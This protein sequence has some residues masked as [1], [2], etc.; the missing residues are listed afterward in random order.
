MHERIVELCSAGNVV[1]AECVSELLQEAGIQARIVGDCL[2]GAAGGLPCGEPIAPRI[3]VCQSDLG[4]A[5]E[6]IDQWCSQQTNE[7]VEFPESETLPESETPVEAEYA[8]LPSDVR[9][10][11]LSQGFFIVGAV[12]IVIGGIWAWKNSM[13]LSIYSGTAVGQFHRI[14]VGDVKWVAPPRER[15]VPPG[16]VAGGSSFHYTYDV[17]YAYVVNGKTYDAT[18]KVDNANRAPNEVTIHYNPRHPASNIAGSITPPWMT[19]LFAS[20]VGAFLCFV[21]YQFR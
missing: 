12:C 21:G 4:H 13:V 15:D 1:E 7:P 19:L 18:M 5:R 10:R 2:G 16:N 8:E 20:L 9:S 3:W 14:R 6:V 17:E 11:F